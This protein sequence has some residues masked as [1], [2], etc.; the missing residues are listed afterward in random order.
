[1]TIKQ[2]WL[3]PDDHYARLL[4]SRTVAPELKKKKKKKKKRNKKVEIKIKKKNK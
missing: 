4:N 1:M 2:T 3:I